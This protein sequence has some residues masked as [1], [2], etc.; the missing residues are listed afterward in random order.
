MLK[1]SAALL[2]VALAACV[3]LSE[4]LVSSLSPEFTST[5][6]GLH[7]ATNAIYAQLRQ[8]WGREQNMAITELGTDIWLNGDQVAA[9][10]AQPWEYLN[11]YTAQLNAADAR[12][13]NFWNPMYVMINRAN[14][15]LEKGPSTPLAQTLS[16]AQ[17]D[18]RLGEAHFFR[19]LAYFELVQQF[20][21]VTI[22]TSAAD[23]STEAS[24]APA[25]EVYQLILADLDSAMTLLPTTQTEWGRVRRAAAK[26]LRAKVYLT[27]GY[28][29]YADGTNG[30]NDF[31]RALADARDVITGVDG[32]YSLVPVYADLWCGRH[33]PS[34]PADPNRMGFC[35]VTT[36]SGF[37]E[38]N[39]EI[40]F[41]VQYSYDTQQYAPGFGNFLHLSYLTHYDNDAATSQGLPR[42]LDNGRPFRRLRASPY[43]IH[44]FDQTR[45]AGTPGA[46][47]ILDT[48]FDGSFQTLWFANTNAA[49]NTT[50]PCPRCTSGAAIVLGDTALWMPGYPVTNAFRQTKKFTII[51]PYADV[52]GTIRDATTG[53]INPCP[54]GA[55]GAND[56]N[57]GRDNKA[58]RVYGWELS[59]ALKKYQDNGR[60]GGI[61]D[62]AGGKDLIMMRLGET[63]LIAA[64][65]AVRLG[66]ATD[67]ATYVNA[68]RVR[69]ASAAHKADPLIMV[70]PGQMT[71]DFIMDERA[72]ELAGEL[73]RYQDLIRPGA[74]FFVDRVRLRNPEAR[75][76]V[77]TFH[78]LRPIPQQQING[79][80]GTPYTQ[81]PGY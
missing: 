1:T 6:D 16:Q 31:T 44:L 52:S 60:A 57:C 77:Q 4:K 25:A 15:V 70:T 22:N 61:A 21:D 81:N 30:V 2:T 13:Q 64:E 53:A 26:H 9:G 33:G 28:K 78:A 50:T 49:A 68:L 43:L 51:E 37:T 34:K 54:V 29:S 3:D 55:P 40:L 80:T 35:D 23:L 8:Y 71:L 18:S 46:S 20:G 39:S 45:W 74:Q 24:R 72:R 42:D 19:A 14:I 75:T 67:A 47:D 63:Y 69:A 36:G 65:A 32:T 27:R 38:Q 5:P 10:G 48:R 17:K 73:N 7:A 66:N 11:T 76:N 59:P 56:A 12:L 62:E 41:S 79:V 58:N